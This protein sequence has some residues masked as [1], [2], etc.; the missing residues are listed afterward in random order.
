MESI[1]KE[2]VIKKYEQY[3]YAE[4]N[5]SIAT[6]DIYITEAGIFM[7]YIKKSGKT[8]SSVGI[9]DIENY[10]IERKQ[11][12][13]GIS[14][15]FNSSVFKKNKNIIL[16]PVTINK[17][18]SSIRAFFRFLQLENIRIDN[19]ARF[20]ESLRT[21]KKLP[22]CLS[23]EDIDNLLNS[24]DISIPAGLRDRALFELIYSCGLRI[25]EAC[26]LR[27]GNIFENDNVIRI[28]G[29]GNKYRIIPEGEI[30]E[31]W[32]K[33]YLAEG[34][35]LLLNDKKNDFIFINFRGDPIGRK[36]V[37][38][39]FK[40]LSRL[41]GIE[42][43]VHTLRHSFATHLLA[44]GADLRSIQ[45]M[46]GHSDISTTQIYTHL[47]RNDLKQCHVKYHPEGIKKRGKT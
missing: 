1:K 40:E 44:G 27:F 20:I 3:L 37:W 46:L 2:N 26:S 6:V 30:A 33:K 32:L 18:E 35:P 24:I 19:P 25:S 15:N 12:N 43:K 39:R 28:R 42:S 31:Y 45:E 41:C 21:D 11:N 7:R 47:G 13:I 10:I 16:S 4:L 38:K 14:N 36:G 9:A 5:L 22:A 23:V 8:L 34:R 17:I 29:K